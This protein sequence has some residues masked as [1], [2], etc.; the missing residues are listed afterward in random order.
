LRTRYSMST[1]RAPGRA[2]KKSLSTLANWMGRYNE[3][4][5]IIFALVAAIWVLV[6]YRG[7]QEETRIERAIDYMKRSSMGELLA[8]E[9]KMTQYWTDQGIVQK[10]ESMPKGDKKIFAD[11]ISESVEKSLKIE[12]WRVFNFYNS[13]AICVNGQ[14]CDPTAACNSF[15]RDIKVFIEN[16]GPYFEQYRAIHYDDALKPIRTMLAHKACSSS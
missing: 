12:V 2:I 11:F 1:P 10:L 7:K 14:L 8:A 4:I 16:Y 15:K 9:L 3:Q 13:L 5:K 6:E